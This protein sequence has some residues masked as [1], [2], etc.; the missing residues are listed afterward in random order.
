[1]TSIRVTI[2]KRGLFWYACCEIPPEEQETLYCDS[3]PYETIYSS[4]VLD[5]IGLTYSRATNKLMDKIKQYFK[6]RRD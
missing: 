4:V 3:N 1:M 2:F 6:E 5:S